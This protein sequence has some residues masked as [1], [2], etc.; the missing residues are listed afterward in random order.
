VWLLFVS[1]SSLAQTPPAPAPEAPPPRRQLQGWEKP[2][3][4]TGL[5][6]TAT[7]LIGGYVWFDLES[8]TC[9]DEGYT[10]TGGG[11]GDGCNAAVPLLL[12]LGGAVTGLTLTGI[13]A[14]GLLVAPKEGVTVTVTGR[15]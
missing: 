1:V 14:V 7:S 9:S 12:G 2:S 3:L 15:F 4:Y 6:L 13:G 8:R 5:A 10:T 11:G